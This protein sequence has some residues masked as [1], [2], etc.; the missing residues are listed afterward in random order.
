MRLIKEGGYVF[1]TVNLYCERLGSGWFV[2]PVFVEP[3]N[4]VSN[5]IFF[6]RS[7]C[8]LARR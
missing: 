4:V 7:I 3:I 5:R 1:E 8:R 2:E 6:I